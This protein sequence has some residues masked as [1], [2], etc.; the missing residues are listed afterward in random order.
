[1]LYLHAQ[2]R[3]Q[4]LNMRGANS[5][6]DIKDGISHYIKAHDRVLIKHEIMGWN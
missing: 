2:G 5:I 4:D 6:G 1:M 3:S